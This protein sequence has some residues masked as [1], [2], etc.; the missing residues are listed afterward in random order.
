MKT[1]RLS[2]LQ[3]GLALLLTAVLA[4]AGEGMGVGPALVLID[5]VTPGAVIDLGKKGLRY[6][7]QN[8]SEVEKILNME[9]SKPGTYSIKEFEPGY[10]PLPNASWLTLEQTSLTVP[11]R[12]DGTSGVTIHIPDA[13]EHWNR[14]YVAYV[15]VGEG[16]KVALGA[17][18]RVRARLLIETAVRDED[19]AAPTTEIAVTPGRI[20][21]IRDQQ[22][23]RGQAKI[24]NQGPLATFDVLTLAEIYPGALADR[25]QRYYPGHVSAIAD[26]ALVK[27]DVTEFTLASGESRVVTVQSALRETPTEKSID[28]VRFI[29]R[30]APAEATN[31][32]EAK[33]RRY[34]RIELLRVRHSP[35]AKETAPTP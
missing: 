25:H 2:I 1:I 26:D 15:E 10:E 22:G 6:I 30:R 17:T 21:L 29:A 31:V 32:R 24:R 12:S 34:D 27:T 3:R 35:A 13:P 23:W 33:G 5:D 28:A 20:S 18:L 14:H 9:I 7:A 8:Q 4:P 11:P 19:A 16:G